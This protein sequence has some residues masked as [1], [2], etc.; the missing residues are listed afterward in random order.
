MKQNDNPTTKNNR[1][2]ETHF[3]P[4]EFSERQNQ[5]KTNKDF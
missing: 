3:T 5:R 1:S 2:W 4:L